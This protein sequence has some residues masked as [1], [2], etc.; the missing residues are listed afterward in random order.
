[1]NILVRLPNWLGDMVMSTAFV[2]ALQTTY[3]N[4]SIDVIAKS[5]LGD[6]LD[7]MNNINEKYLFNK[8]D[9]KGLSGAYQFGKMIRNKK[10]Y[11]L[12][13]CLPDSFSSALMGFATGAKKR[14]GYKKELRSFLLT[15]KFTKPTGLH[16]VDEYVRLLELFTGTEIKE[17]KV[18]LMCT[19]AEIENRMVINFNSEAS[20]RRMPVAKAISIMQI[21]VQQFTEHEFVFIGTPAEKEFVD[22]IVA[23]VPAS[24]N[25]LV[26]KAGTTGVKEL[27]N[28]IA[29][30]SVLLTTDSGPAHIANALHTKTVVLFGAGNE[31]NTAPYNKNDVTVIRNGT[32]PC[33]PCVSNSCRFGEP[34]C[35]L[36]LKNE[37]I[38]E[39][40]VNG[41]N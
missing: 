13:F 3:Q 19:A 34:K 20:S 2:Q 4:A 21:L 22:S 32:L 18:E 25:T 16:R 38:A 29:S 26:N 30:A 1:M 31:K 37:I 27:F 12:F 36:L 8:K 9:W 24:T 35:L 6:V 17:R 10:K 15:Q 11:D 7:A 14:I 33:E 23:Q 41:K 28:L 39:A 5:N 40:V